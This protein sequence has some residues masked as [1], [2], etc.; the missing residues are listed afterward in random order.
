MLQNYATY[1]V[2]SGSQNDLSSCIS[3]DK[4]SYIDILVTLLQNENDKSSICHNNNPKCSICPLDE[5]KELSHMVQQ[6]S[7]MSILPPL[8][9]RL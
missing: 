1:I 6:K 5:L 3:P 9:S 4:I 7:D 8:R 2:S